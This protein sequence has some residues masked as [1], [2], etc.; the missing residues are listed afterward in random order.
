MAK[1]FSFFVKILL[2]TGGY[3]QGVNKVSQAT[4]KMAGNLKESGNALTGIMSQVGGMT[5]EISGMIGGLAGAAT[6]VG[7]VTA[8]VGI[9]I[10]VWKTAKENMDLYL[11]SANKPELGTLGYREQAKDLVKNTRKIGRGGVRVDEAALKE[12]SMRMGSFQRQLDAET[13]E[14]KKKILATQL[15]QVTAEYKSAEAQLEINKAFKEGNQGRNARVTLEMK[16]K[17]LLLAEGMQIVEDEEMAAKWLEDTAKMADLKTIIIDKDTSAAQKAKASADFEVIANTMQKEKLMHIEEEI[18][19]QTDLLSL[20]GK[21]GELAVFLRKKELEKAQIEK[22]NSVFL[23]KK[24]TLENKAQKSLEKQT[25]EAEKRLKTEEDIQKL[26]DETILAGL[27]GNVK[28][29]TALKL[30]YNEDIK[31]A[32]D[33]EILKDA[34]TNEY[35]A[36]RLALQKQYDA[37]EAQANREKQDEIFA[38]NQKAREDEIKAKDEAQQEVL[39]LMKQKH[40]QK[41]VILKVKRLKCNI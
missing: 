37:E 12:N 41:P 13:D 39:L 24:E 32:K 16:F 9:L 40:W 31:K 23:M 25:K 3:T 10:K 14:S 30:K 1:D 21:S 6:G 18:Q 35:I 2:E 27:E 36:K 17:E 29:Q 4:Q 11:K 5:G 22:E 33:N 19:I 15:A 28:E 26:K 34:I 7:L 20:Q 38:N 8:A